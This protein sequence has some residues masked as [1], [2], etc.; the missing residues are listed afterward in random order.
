MRVKT[1]STTR[2][3]R[4][5]W[6]KDAEGF[7]GVNH[8]SYRNAKQAVIKSSQYA[9]RDRKNKKRDFRKLW[10]A[11]INAAVRA[12]GHTYSKFMAQLKAKK[13]DINRKMLSELA[14]H[15]PEEFKKFVHNLMSKK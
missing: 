6:L 4:K 13:I 5:R 7:W 8:S 14:I 1:G 15:N 10:I 12:E 2:Q 9:Y 11:R 3:R